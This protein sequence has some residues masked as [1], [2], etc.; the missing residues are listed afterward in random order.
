MVFGDPLG[1][2]ELSQ[3]DGHGAPMLYLDRAGPEE[4]DAPPPSKSKPT[5]EIRSRGYPFAFL[6]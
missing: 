3:A 5:T 6:I 4:E 2:L 1:E